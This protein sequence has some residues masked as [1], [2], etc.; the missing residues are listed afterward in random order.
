MSALIK[1][2][3]YGIR[4]LWNR[5]AFGAASI[6][7]L[8]LGIGACA[9]IFSIVDAVLL[10]SLPYPH[11]D[12]LVVMKEVNAKGRRANFGE[13]NFTDVRARN[14][15]FE[16]IAEYSGAGIK[17]IG[18]GS[19]PVTARVSVVSADFFRV[20]EINPAVGR[21]FLPQEI[22]TGAPVAVLSYGFWQQSLGG[23]TDVAGTTL[24]LDN[25]S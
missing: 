16:M 1:D 6:V 4:G 10:R 24:R 5:P 22:Q 11:A 25:Q 12:R 15:S 18:G 3:R 14:H 23:K 20:L 19:A 17:N 2:I 13:P 9:A 21:F 8:A 7:S